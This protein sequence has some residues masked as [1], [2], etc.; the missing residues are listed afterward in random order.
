MELSLNSS[1]MGRTIEPFRYSYKGVA[2]TWDPAASNR[3]E[4]VEEL[5]RLLGNIAPED[6]SLFDDLDNYIASG[7]D[8]PDRDFSSRMID[9]I[10]NVCHF[11]LSSSPVS[12][13]HMNIK[14]VSRHSYRRCGER[15]NVR[16]CKHERYWCAH[17]SIFT[18][19]HH[20]TRCM[21]ICGD[22]KLSGKRVSYNG[23]ARR[24][25]DLKDF[26]IAHATTHGT[27]RRPDVC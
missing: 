6:Y 27:R 7:A 5:D 26:C 20:C 22:D 25:A 18:W 17:G 1:M 15:V 9:M 19:W 8:I 12:A 13:D 3:D 10:R 4:L 14:T 11:G 24:P 16:T 21:N 2:Y 23:N